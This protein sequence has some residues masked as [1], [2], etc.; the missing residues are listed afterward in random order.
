MTAAATVAYVGALPYRLVPHKKWKGAGLLGSLAGW[1][2]VWLT[3]GP[4]AGAWV[5]FAALVVFSVVASQIAEEQLG[6]DDPRI[7]IDEVA[8]VWLACIALPRTLWPMTAGLILFR[9]FDVLKGPWGNAAARLPGGWGIVADDLV[10]GAIAWGLAYLGLR[11]FPI[12]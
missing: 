1:A 6:H 5:I 12:I 7:V 10:A 11:L 9:I 8:G 2:L 3:P 4:T